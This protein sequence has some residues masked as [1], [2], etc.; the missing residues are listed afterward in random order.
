[1]T[2][3]AGSTELVVDSVP[4]YAAQFDGGPCPDPSRCEYRHRHASGPWT[5]EFND[6]RVMS[7]SEAA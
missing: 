7:E 5:C 6:P 2:L 1:M 4:E 3:D